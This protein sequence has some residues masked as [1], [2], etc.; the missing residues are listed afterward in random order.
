MAVPDLAQIVYDNGDTSNL[1]CES[2]GAPTNGNNVIGLPY[3]GIGIDPSIIDLDRLDFRVEAQGPSVTGASIVSLAG[4]KL[5]VTLNFDQS[6][7][8]DALV[9]CTLNHTIIS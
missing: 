5:S 6:G 3:V 7:S 8:D 2:Q 1:I 9:R 4:D